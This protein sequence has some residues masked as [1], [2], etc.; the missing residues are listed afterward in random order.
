MMLKRVYEYVKD[1]EFRFTIF[2]NRVHVMNYK[3][4][5][6]LKNEEISFKGEGKFIL[7]KGNDLILN[8]LLDDEFLIVG[9]IQTIEVFNDK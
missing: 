1:D 8:K 4:I 3:K 6:S 5:L 9:N 2:S 7:V